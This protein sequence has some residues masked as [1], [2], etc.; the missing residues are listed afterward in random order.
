MNEHSTTPGSRRAL[1]ARFR[2][3][4]EQIRPPWTRREEA[5]QDACTLCGNCLSACPTGVLVKGHAG[6]PI[7][8]FSKAECTF[9]GK[10]ADA[11]KEPCFS[12]RDTK[13]WGLTAAISALCVEPKGVVCRVC[14]ESCPANAI[15]FKPKLGGG[16]TPVVNLANCTGCG[17][18]VRPC[19]VRAISI[20][21]LHSAETSS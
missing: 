5:F 11:C 12:P 2:G 9:C 18:C 20:S 4:P 7:A 15:S 10:C 21:N 1:F 13:P 16:A 19:P 3:G 8:D 6:Y 14:E 17:A